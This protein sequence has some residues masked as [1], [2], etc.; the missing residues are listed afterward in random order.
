MRRDCAEAAASSS[1]NVTGER[2][3]GVLDALDDAAKDTGAKKTAK[4]EAHGPAAGGQ[5][6]QKLDASAEQVPGP[7]RST[8]HRWIRGACRSNRS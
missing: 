2:G 4:K 8:I 6:Q 3:A 7:A 1:R 5:R